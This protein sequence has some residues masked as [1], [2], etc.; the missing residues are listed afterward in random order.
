MLTWRM[1]G[2]LLTGWISIIL[3]NICH[4][5]IVKSTGCRPMC[6][7]SFYICSLF[8][9]QHPSKKKSKLEKI[10]TQTDGQTDKRLL[11]LFGLPLLALGQVTFGDLGIVKWSFF[12]LRRVICDF[13]QILKICLLTL[14]SLW[15][16]QQRIYL[17]QCIC[18]STNYPFTMRAMWFWLIR[19]NPPQK[20]YKA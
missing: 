17:E 9:S 14:V 20:Y 7:D 2:L 4:N 1:V 15:R 6:Y 10:N 12:M 18:L 5:S 19:P 16:A 11:Y 13:L 3:R 8:C